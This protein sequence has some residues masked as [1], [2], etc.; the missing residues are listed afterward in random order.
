[1]SL[2][3]LQLARKVLESEQRPLTI[4]QI[5]EIAKNRGYNNELNS[6]GK[7]PWATL[8]AM[9]HV[10]VRDNPNSLFAAM[11]A[12]PMRFV[13]KTLVESRGNQI[14]QIP[15]VEEKKSHTSYA[16]ITLHPFM[17]YY[18]FY[19]LKAHL[20]TIRHNKSG[21]N[22]YGEWV[23]PDI[24]GCY[25]SFSDLQEEVVEV[26]SLAGTASIK[27]FSF[28]LKRELSFSNLREAF[29]QAVSNS[30]WANEGYLVAAEINQDEE[31][32]NELKRLSTSFGIGVIK[33]DVQEPDSSEVIFPARSKDLVDWET[34]NKLA[35]MNPDFREFLKRVKTDIT[36]REARKEM[37]DQVLDSEQ[38]IK[39][40]QEN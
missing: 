37:Y 22:S 31:F 39:S 20:K 38:L 13:L 3:F 11:G 33:L 5:W 27:L 9:V 23:H 6:H 7:T 26:S 29:F 24:V 25:Y 1:M 35:G 34:V 12:R 14:L 32:Q 16:E 4:N 28:E 40:I 10:D 8:G 2:T 17:V 36:S 15:L 18:G 19:Y 21:K 30:S